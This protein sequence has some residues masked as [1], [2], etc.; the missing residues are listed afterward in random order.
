MTGLCINNGPQP[1][2]LEPNPTPR[3]KAIINEVLL[4]AASRSLCRQARDYACDVNFGLLFIVP[5]ARCLALGR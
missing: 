2:T 3:A 1:G 4:T 5:K